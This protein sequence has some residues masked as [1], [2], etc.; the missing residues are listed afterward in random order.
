MLWLLD[1]HK[2][3]KSENKKPVTTTMADESALAEKVGTYKPGSIQRIKLHNFLTY[4]DVEF[5]PGPRYVT[6][7]WIQFV[8]D[9]LC[10]VV[11]E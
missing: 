3:R 5:K 6:L 9:L 4:Q 11:D 7:R 2:Q 1:A 10:R 8:R